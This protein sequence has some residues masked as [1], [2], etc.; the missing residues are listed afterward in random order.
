MLGEFRS[1]QTL[2]DILNRDYPLDSLIQFYWLPILR[3][4]IAFCK[5]QYDEALRL[6]GQSN[7]YDLGI[8]SPGQCMDLSLLRGQVLLAKG[9]APAAAQQFRA[10]LAHRGLVLNCPTVALARL[11]L[12]RAFTATGQVADSRSTYQDIF[13]LWKNADAGLPLLRQAQAEYRSLPH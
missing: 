6:T 12:A 13:A 8:F 11:G 5:A 4:R 1:A 9:Q 7:P 10:V 2:I 3:V